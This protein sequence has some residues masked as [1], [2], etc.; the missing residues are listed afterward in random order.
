M[1]RD[2][3]AEDPQAAIDRI[4]EVGR[5]TRTPPSR[6]LWIAAIVVGILAV[7]GFAI[8]MLAEPEPSERPE[9]LPDGSG[10]L[11]GLVIGAAVG[12]VIGYSIARQ[13]RDHSSRNSP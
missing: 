7:A 11:S 9:R 6:A 10:L 3:Q 12:I 13:R 2:E 4:I 8:A 1:G 5:R